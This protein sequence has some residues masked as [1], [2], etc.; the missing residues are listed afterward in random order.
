[1]STTTQ[2]TPTTPDAAK[3]GRR[4]LSRRTVLIGAGATVAGLGTAAYVGSRAPEVTFAS[5]TFGSAGPRILV[6]Y[7]SQYGSTGEIAR[8]IG[9]Q[10]GAQARVDVRPASAVTSLGSYAALVFGAPVQKNVMKESATTWL[11]EHAAEVNRI[12]H[13]YFMPSA[14]FGID[15]DRAGQTARKTGLLEDAAALSG[16]SPFAL[17]PMGGLVDFS[18]MAYIN[19]LIYRITA[20]NGIQG[21]FRDFGAVETWTDQIRT[22]LLS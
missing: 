6:A 8:A 4:G 12:P 15:P 10:L 19:S 2:T 13:A 18:R 7:D 5:D 17:L 14:S 9:A 20:G 3:P 1:M 11:R 16:T 22:R 21:D